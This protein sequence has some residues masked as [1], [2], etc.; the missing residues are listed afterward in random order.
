M[1][2]TLVAIQLTINKAVAPLRLDKD[3]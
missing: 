3:V 2:N 1:D